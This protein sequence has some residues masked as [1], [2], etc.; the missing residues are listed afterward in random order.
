[1][2]SLVIQEILKK[3][4]ITDYLARKGIFPA[5]PEHNGKIKYRCPLHE[6]D[7]DPSFMVYTNGEYEN[8]FCYGCRNRYNIIHLYSLLEKVPLKKTLQNLGDGLGIDVNSE[9]D[10]TV[11]EIQNDDSVWSEYTPVQLSLLVARLSY[12]F[13]EKVE[14]DKSCCESVDK[15][16]ITVDKMAE[17]GDLLGLKKLLDVLP[18]VMLKKIQELENKIKV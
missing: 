13:L 4:K 3:H 5:V 2:A 14:K 17:S 10:N 12:E 15:L 11:K 7:N 18:E 8:F 1:M 9:I 16:M 6:G